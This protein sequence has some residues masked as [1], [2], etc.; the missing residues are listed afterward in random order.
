VLPEARRRGLARRVIRA[1]ADWAA[2][3]GATGAFLQVEQR[4]T[5]AVT[6]YRG[7]GFTTHH[8]YLTRVAPD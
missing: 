5:P 2:D 3:Q 4:N 1:L 8:T 7:L 6:L